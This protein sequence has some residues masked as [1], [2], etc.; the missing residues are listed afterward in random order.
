MEIKKLKEIGRKEGLKG[1][2]L[3]AFVCFFEER[4]PEH[5]SLYARDWA[6]RFKEGDISGKADRESRKVFIDAYKTAIGGF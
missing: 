3:T 2:H 4:F 5:D 1:D 6:Q